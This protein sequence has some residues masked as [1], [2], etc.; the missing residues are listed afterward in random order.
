MTRAKNCS[1]CGAPFEA[2]KSPKGK[3]PSTCS[4][5]CRL[6][7]LDRL[8][9]VL[10]K[11]RRSLAATLGENAGGLDRGSPNGPDL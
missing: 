9:E 11:K 8:I 6:A 5:E 1:T 4:P 2:V 10:T 7:A 3:W